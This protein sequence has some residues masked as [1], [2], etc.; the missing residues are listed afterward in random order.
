MQHSVVLDSQGYI[1]LYYEEDSTDKDFMNFEVHART[2]GWVAIGFSPNGAMTASD[3]AL[4]WVDQNGMPQLH[5][6]SGVARGGGGARRWGLR[7]N[8]R[9][10]FAARM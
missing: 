2:R 1:V 5:V 3:I 6:S 4:G 10:D 9:G 8:P 7:P